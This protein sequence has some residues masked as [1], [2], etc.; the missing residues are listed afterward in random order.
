MPEDRASWTLPR[1]STPSRRYPIGVPLRI[2]TR[3]KSS[4]ESPR[5]R[6]SIAP[7][8]VV[9][10][11]LS[12]DCDVRREASVPTLKNARFPHKTAA[13]GRVFSESLF[14]VGGSA[15][16]TPRVPQQSPPKRRVLRTACAAPLR[17]LARSAE[18]LVR[19][20]RGTL[21]AGVG[22]GGPGE[23]RPVG[24]ACGASAG[25]WAEREAERRCSMRRRSAWAPAARGW[26]ATSRAGSGAAATPAAARS[27]R[28]RRSASR[29]GS[30]CA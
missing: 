27:R 16:D 24:S 18:A 19:L 2:P 20:H 8:L 10:E 21:L 30:R 17:N 1:R 26:G 25:A 9:V 6:C 11:R 29:P 15:P 5:R 4:I 12:S 3:T 14:M 7:G 22:L 28:S 23:A 13:A